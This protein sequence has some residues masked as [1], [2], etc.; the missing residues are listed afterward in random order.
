MRTKIKKFT[1][2]SDVKV[3]TDALQNKLEALGAELGLDIK[4]TKAGYTDYKCTISMTAYVSDDKGGVKVDDSTL[5]VVD[6]M[7]DIDG[8][9]YSTPH[10]INSLWRIA[11]SIYKVIDYN[12]RNRSYPY[13]VV[14]SDGKRHKCPKTSF[15][16]EVKAPTEN[17]FK[18]WFTIDPDDDSVS[19]KNEE[20]CDRVSE[21]MSAAYP[22]EVYDV[23]C[24]IY[25]NGTATDVWKTAY[26]LLF[27]TDS[28]YEQI[29]KSLK[30]SMAYLGRTTK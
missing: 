19:K 29:V 3:L 6:T 11:G 23:C 17:E 27:Q 21:Y 28:T 12:S 10:F 20:I 4:I 30:L 8:I 16:I 24:E 7:A 2:S 5:S 15:T 26:S 9:K 22:K 14:G 1:D 13:I 18:V 25:E